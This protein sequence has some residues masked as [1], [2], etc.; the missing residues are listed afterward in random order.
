MMKAYEGPR[1]TVVAASLRHGE[2]RFVNSGAEITEASPEDLIFEIGSITKVFTAILLCLLVEEGKVDPRAPLRHMSGD[3]A[4]VPDWITP[5]RLISHTSGLPNFHMPI[6]KALMR[7]WPDGPYVGFS[8]SDLLKWLHSW[9]GRASEPRPRHAY[10][11]LGIGLL[12]EAM[13][14]Q[15]GMPF[16]NLLAEK[17]V[18]P[19]GLKDTT[20]CLGDDRNGRLAHPRYPSGKPVSPWRFEAL[21]A[22]G[23]LRS[24]AH[25][26]ARF[27]IRVMAAL[28]TPETSMDRAIRQSA[29]PVFGLGRRGCMDPSAQC[30]GWLS[31][32]PP[33]PGPRFL[34]HN[35]GTAGSTCALY[36]CPEKAEAC[37]VLSN[38]GIAGNLW[39]SIKL[40]W[41]NQITQAHEYFAAI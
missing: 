16:I 9:R 18:A 21:A 3:L 4:G 20:H 24:S 23:C 30:S 11:N 15:E 29:I 33:K 27:A 14:M 8:R 17:V 12:G 35:G 39:G 26:L 7:P 40:D 28:N 22:A 25:D 38:N 41:S 2:P 34:Y 36:I 31:M 5:E 6:W 1:H 32:K 10:S 13:A 37:A 19:L